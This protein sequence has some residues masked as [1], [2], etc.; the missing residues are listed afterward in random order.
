MMND[1]RKINAFAF[2]HH[3][4]FIIPHSSFDSLA[5]GARAGASLM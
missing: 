5:S 3:S 1:E 4:S 2:I